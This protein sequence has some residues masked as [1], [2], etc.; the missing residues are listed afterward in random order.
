MV[1]WPGLLQWSLRH[2]DGTHN[3]SHTPPLTE[4]QRKWLDEA[5]FSQGKDEVKEMVKLA[6]KVEETFS[7]ENELESNCERL[8]QI[9]DILTNLDMDASFCKVGAATSLL[10]LCIH[11][12]T[13][14]LLRQSLLSTI[15]FA[16]ANSWFVQNFLTNAGFERLVD[17]ARDSSS[18]TRLRSLSTLRALVCGESLA[19]L[20]LFIRSGGVSALRQVMQEE[21]NAQ[22]LSCA[23]RFVTDLVS[24]E[25]LITLS[26]DRLVNEVLRSSSPT[27]E[28]EQVASILKS[29]YSHLAEALSRCADLAAKEP[30]EG[31]GT[32]LH[33]SLL[34]CL[35]E[36]SK[37]VDAASLRS[38]A[39]NFLLFC[40]KMQVLDT[41]DTEARDMTAFLKKQVC[42]Q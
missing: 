10:E 15:K 2:N 42:S 26:G 3:A 7:D 28:T 22:V 5:L 29:E 27:A 21:T 14:A 20:R 34:K 12:Q 6:A 36:I 33:S 19:N 13:P 41:E 31:P 39:E 18:L 32:D 17:L 37:K 38:S 40:E 8:A 24:S 1:S 23:L 9:E 35:C 25:E 16:A 11:A 30:L 4:E